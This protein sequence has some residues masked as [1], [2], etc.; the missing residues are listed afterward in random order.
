MHP[1]GLFV[2]KESVRVEAS[3]LKKPEGKASQQKVTTETTTPES[4][5]TGSVVST[6]SSISTSEDLVYAASGPAKNDGEDTNDVLV[7]YEM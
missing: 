5:S 4:P 1:S 2:H 3:N 6:S 7:V